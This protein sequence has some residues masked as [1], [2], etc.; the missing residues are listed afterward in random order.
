M[1]FAFFDAPYPR[2][3]AHRGE[4]GLCPENTMEA[5]QHAVDA[6]ITLLETDAHSTADGHLVL[7]HDALL[8]R[9]TNGTGPL[10]SKTFAELQTLDAGYRFTRDG[11]KSFPFRDRDVRIPLLRDVIEAFPGVKFNIEAKQADP[12]IADR[13]VA[14]FRELGRADDVLIAC[15]GDVVRDQLDAIDRGMPRNFSGSEVLEFLQ[16]VHGD[17][18]ASYTPPAQALQIPE[19]YEG[20]PLLSP[21]LLEAAKHLG[22]EVHI[23]T[24]N[25]PEDMRRLL[26]TG[27]DGIMSDH[28]TTLLRV[29]NDLAPR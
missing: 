3:F 10:K 25:E 8:E 28:P 1:S 29:A 15:E 18:L 22:L 14:L 4:S 5:F 9:T 6:G 17:G 27:V 16:A 20:I 13:M 7:H 21:R 12:P 23:W 2:L 24:V 26:D 19:V 11:G